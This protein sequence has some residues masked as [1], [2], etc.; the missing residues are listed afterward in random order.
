MVAFHTVKP[1]DTLYDCRMVKAGHTTMRRMSV[2]DV[3]IVSVH[4]NHVIAKW[5][6][7]PEKRFSRRDVERWRRTPPKPNT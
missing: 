5:N 2:W 1:G 4:E 6:G 3:C 7:N